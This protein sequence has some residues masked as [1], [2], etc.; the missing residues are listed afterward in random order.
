MYLTKIFDIVTFAIAVIGF[1]LSIWNFVETRIQNRVNL[2][3]ECK[4]FIIADNFARKPL[5]IALS[6]VNK[7]R[8]PIA[9]SRAFIVAANEKFEFSW[10]PQIVHQARLGTKDEVFDRTIVKSI[11]LPI[12]LSG[13]G[14]IGGYFYTETFDRITEDL[15]KETSATIVLHTNRGVKEYSVELTTIA[16]DI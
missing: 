15:I 4:D 2:S 12:N 8:L 14:T 7:S 5:Y 1:I 3:V 13:L 9:V 6:V 11:T 10:I 16:T